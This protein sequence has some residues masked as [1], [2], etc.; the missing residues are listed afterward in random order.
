MVSIHGRLL[1]VDFKSSVK[2]FIQWQTYAIA[3]SYLQLCCCNTVM[4]WRHRQY[5]CSSAG[6]DVWVFGAEFPYLQCR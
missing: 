1:S 2:H 3:A 5:V 6:D 4:L